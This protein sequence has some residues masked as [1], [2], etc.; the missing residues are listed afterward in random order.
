MSLTHDVTAR[1]SAGIGPRTL[2]YLAAGCWAA[3]TPTTS[4]AIT[5][6]MPVAAL[7][8]V[9][10]AVAT[11]WQFTF[12]LLWLV[13]FAITQAQTGSD[14]IVTLVGSATPT[15]WPLALVG[16]L[17][18]AAS[19]LAFNH[20]VRHVP[21]AEA[22]II[23]NLIPVLGAAIGVIWLGNVLTVGAML[24]GAVTIVGIL[25]LAVQTAKPTAGSSPARRLDLPQQRHHEH[26]R[27]NDVLGAIRHWIHNMCRQMP[28][29]LWR[30]RVGRIEAGQSDDHG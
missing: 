20:A 2:L 8:H 11:A 21:I 18:L 6:Q 15:S 23:L 10:V 30:R 19:C 3:Y 13:A 5:K 29:E 9:Q 7:L 22:G 24:G 1:G 17:L 26:H 28:V 27:H 25:I 14:T 12:G 4:L 16:G